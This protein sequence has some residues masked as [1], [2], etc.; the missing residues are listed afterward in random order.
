ME[1]AEV[2]MNY[3]NDEIFKV[4]ESFNQD[5]NKLRDEIMQKFVELE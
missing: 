4:N 2:L 3:T 1:E 5:I